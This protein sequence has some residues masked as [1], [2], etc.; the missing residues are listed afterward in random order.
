VSGGVASPLG[1]LPTSASA[2]VEWLALAG[3][4][5]TAVA[6]LCFKRAMG[7]GAARALLAVRW[8]TGAAAMT[9]AMLSSGGWS[10]LHLSG[11]VLVLAFGAICG[12]VVG[13]LL[14]L[15]A[16]P[17]LAVSVAQPIF[18]SSVV[19]AMALAVLFLGERPNSFTWLGAVLVLVGVHLLHQAG[20]R[21]AR[22]H[23]PRTAAAR[24]ASDRPLWGRLRGSPLL[25]LALASAGCT[26]I[27]S[28]CFKVGVGELPPLATNWVRTM[29]P[30]CVLG[31][32]FLAG[33]LPLGASGAARSE[34][35]LTARGAALAVAAGVANDVI[36]WGLRLFAL[37]HGPLT[38][39]EPLAATSPLFAALLGAW[40]L[41][42]RIGRRG[43]VGI[44]TT[45]LGGLLLGGLGR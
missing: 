31:G 27:A 34:P 1:T 23:L 41:G 12:P 29:V 14:Y 22:Q 25:A 26:G 15:R 37:Q 9:L 28:F 32:L 6:H 45:V 35:V 16:L 2:P 30:S 3:A 44:G 33:T 36:G 10:A 21:R 5:G 4:V 13:W 24:E 43:W 18:N 17:H 7:A 42:E 40:V 38:V 8:S 39:V 19:V 20:L 11:A